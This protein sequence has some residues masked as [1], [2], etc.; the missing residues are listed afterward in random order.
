MSELAAFTFLFAWSRSR[1]ATTVMSVP[2]CSILNRG[3]HPIS[4]RS[5]SMTGVPLVP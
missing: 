4:G 3:R 5:S 1:D 2:A